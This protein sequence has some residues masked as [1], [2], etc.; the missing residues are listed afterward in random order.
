MRA[1]G[2]GAGP[3][4]VPCDASHDAAKE[5]SMSERTVWKA[6]A[7]AGW[8]AALPV[9]ASGET[10]ELDAAADATLIESASGALA[11]GAG[12][13]F[14]VGRTGQSSSSRRRA[15]IAF[16]VAAAVPAGAVVTDARLALSLSP[17]N[18]APIEIGVYRV[19]ADWSEGPSAATGGSG[20]ASL[21]GDVTWIHRRYDDEPWANPGGD[22]AAQPSAVAEVGDTGSYRFGSTALMA[23]VQSWL[24]APAGNHGWILVGGEEA[25]STAKRFYSR[26]VTEEGAGPRLVIEYVPA[27]EAAGLSAR[28][29]G[30]CHAY[31]EAL[32]CDGPVP[33]GDARACEL[34]AQRF[35]AATGGRALP[36][37]PPPPEDAC[38]CF[39]RDDVTALVLGLEDASLYTDLDCI[40]SS[41]AKPFT[42]V[43]ALRV[44][45]TD[46]SAQSADCSALAVTFTEDNACQ[47][48]PPVP[49][50]PLVVDGISDE[51]RDAC[52]GAILDGAFAAGLACE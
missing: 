2:F 48:N 22:F 40:D 37:E 21:P 46:C 5:R 47:F 45:G 1:G 25:A 4:H 43:S 34:L 30:P 42:A 29:F 16:D 49:G 28:A 33:R 19:S 14:F 20:V 39:T 23:D 18:P 7:L 11:N 50:V 51:E 10:I 9:G 26:E 3:R 6:V 8:L 41:P 15:V 32:D 13:A 12:P 27:C 35:G 31:C 17:S 24:D 52:R 38:P 36:C 44:D